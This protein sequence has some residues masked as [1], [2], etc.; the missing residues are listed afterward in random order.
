M[1]VEAEV[2]GEDIVARN[3][4]EMSRRA[5]DLRPA[6]KQIRT[7]LIE[8][9][10][11]NWLSRGAYLGDTWPPLAQS[12]VQRWGSGEL[13]VA[14]GKLK[15]AIMGGSGSKTTASRSSVSVGVNV[16]EAHLFAGGRSGGRGGTQP[17]RKIIG[18][19][20][21]QIGQANDI[22]RRFIVEGH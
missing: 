1:I 6:A 18:V 20:R 5:S 9:H 7:L 10:K 4:L 13:G 11:R 3:L 15:A 22:L 14:S 2:I 21:G 17:P 8:G 16:P 12:T 19:N